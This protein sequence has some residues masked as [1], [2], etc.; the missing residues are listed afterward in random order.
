[1]A[2]EDKLRDYLKKAIADARDA[3][4]QLREA[5]DRQHEPIAIVG[6]ACRYPGGVTSPDELWRLVAEGTDA[7]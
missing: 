2:G 4:R 6:M 1:M 7:I 5:E 3:R